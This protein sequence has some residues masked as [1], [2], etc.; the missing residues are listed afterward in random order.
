M[1]MLVAFWDIVCSE[2]DKYINNHKYIPYRV[3]KGVSVSKLYDGIVVVHTSIQADW[4]RG[5]FVLMPERCIEF[6]TLLSLAMRRKDI[7]RVQDTIEHHR[8]GKPSS[9]LSFSTG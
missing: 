7:V 8:R 2:R 4:D 6:A 1:N 9:I 3:R 5:D